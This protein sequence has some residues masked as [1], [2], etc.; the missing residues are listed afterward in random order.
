MNMNV[1]TKRSRRD[2]IT[3]IWELIVS[4]PR[5]GP[6]E[7]MNGPTN[8][9]S[10]HPSVRPSIRPSIHPSIHPSIQPASHPAS[11]PASQPASQVRLQ[12]ELEHCLCSVQL[13]KNELKKTDKT[14]FDLIR[15][16]RYRVNRPWG[17]PWWNGLFESRDGRDRCLEASWLRACRFDSGF[18]LRFCGRRCQRCWQWWCCWWS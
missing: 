7:I 17:N 1:F 11:H 14:S 15:S 5:V 2:I 9:S 18:C 10:I 6:H 12:G 13:E 16:W 3:N 4:L 8:H